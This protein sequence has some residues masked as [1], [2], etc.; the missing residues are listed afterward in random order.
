MTLLISTGF[1]LKVPYWMP[2]AL[3][4]IFMVLA[5]NKSLSSATR[6]DLSGYL[7]VDRSLS[8]VANLAQK[9]WKTAID[10]HAAGK[11]HILHMFVHL[12]LYFSLIFVV[13]KYFKNQ[14]VNYVINTFKL[15]TLPRV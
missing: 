12:I 6:R 8:I 10:F 7:L 3:L 11:I 1:V 15:S 4:V 14:A 2:V 13:I 9:L 5:V